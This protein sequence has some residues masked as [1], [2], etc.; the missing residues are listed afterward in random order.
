MRDRCRWGILGTANIARKNWAAIRNSGNGIV[1]A[2]ASRTPSRAEEYIRQL[3]AE[4]PFSQ[5]PQ[6]CS[7]EELLRRKDVDAVYIP[8]P[9][10]LRAGWVKEAARAG[11][12]VLCEKPCALDAAELREM[13]A[14][15]RDDRVQ[16]M[17]GVMFMHSARLPAVRQVLEDG[18][19]IGTIKR[20]AGQFS[21]LGEQD[22]L[23]GDIRMNSQLEP[24]GC[25]GDLGWYLIRFAL[26]IMN[27]KMPREVSARMLSQQ[28]R[29]DS[30]ASV[31]TEVA[32]DLLF[33]GGVS[34]G[35][36]C[37]FLTENQQFAHVSGT[38]GNLLLS[39]FVLPYVGNE[40][41]FVVS[42]DRFHVAG[43]QFC[44]ER[45]SRRIAVDEY[46]NNAP[47]AQESQLFRTFSEL[48]LSGSNNPYWPEIALQTQMVLDACL[49]SAHNNARLVAVNQNA[50]F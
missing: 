24:H 34:A 28:G 6:A 26:W 45:R 30:P 5:H 23:T 21:F 37:S 32:F 15:C 27:G 17:D 3:Q 50:G 46:A 14:A 4:C 39:D 12:H 8:L 7:Y 22:F 42:N 11:K 49:E 36:Y 13:L 9:T 35:F 47:S 19:S 31:P 41:A 40:A 1:T 38:K 2:V 43:S 25:L 18:E 48:V 20:I 33:D 29:G 44:M 10:G 16:F